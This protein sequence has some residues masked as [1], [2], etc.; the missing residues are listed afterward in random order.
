MDLSG[1][2]NRLHVHQLRTQ[3]PDKEHSQMTQTMSEEQAADATLAPK[4]WR[5][6]N[7]PTVAAALAFANAHHLHAGELSANA[8]NDGTVGM[9]YFD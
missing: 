7:F 8:R 4:Q 2:M 5:F 3:C 9:F 1:V 6:S